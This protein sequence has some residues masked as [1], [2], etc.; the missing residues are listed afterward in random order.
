MRYSR[1][2][3]SKILRFDCGNKRARTSI[4]ISI[5]YVS[6]TIKRR[7]PSPGSRKK[8]PQ[9]EV[10]AYGDDSRKQRVLPTGFVQGA[11]MAVRF[12]ELQYPC[13][14]LRLYIEI[15]VQKGRINNSLSWLYYSREGKVLRAAKTSSDVARNYILLA[16]SQLVFTDGSAAK[17]LPRALTIPPATQASRIT[18]D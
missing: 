13:R 9:L 7:T 2:K 3:V 8:R 16:A 4:S 17:T 15:G 6:T 1:E 12:R 11:V 10:A 18:K 5:N 14:E